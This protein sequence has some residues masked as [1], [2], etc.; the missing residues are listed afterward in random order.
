MDLHIYVNIYT[1]HICIILIILLFCL[2]Y[3]LIPFREGV[4]T[5]NH[6]TRDPSRPSEY[7]LVT[8]F[9]SL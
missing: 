1:H 7:Y 9:K 5:Y 8:T 6:K 2:W 4:N 3:I